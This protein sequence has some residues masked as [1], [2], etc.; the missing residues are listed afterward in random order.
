MAGF[1]LDGDGDCFEAGDEVEGAFFWDGCEALRG[2]GADGQGAGWFC[3]A[4]GF[5]VGFG[6]GFGGL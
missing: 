5:W 1:H 6:D 2:S 4:D 3:D